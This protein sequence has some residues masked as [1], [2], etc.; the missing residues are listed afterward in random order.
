M[1]L[2]TGTQVSRALRKNGHKVILL[3]VFLGYGDAHTDLAG[4]FDRW[5]E[6]SAVTGEISGEA[7][8][9]AKVK[10]MRRD[11]SNCFLAECD[12]DV[13]GSGHCVYGASW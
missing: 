4:I 12:P 3:D 10:A 13:S 9:I 1:S 6:V 7:P 11:P 8:D 2:I 5:E